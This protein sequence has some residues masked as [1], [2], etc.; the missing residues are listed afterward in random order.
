MYSFYCCLQIIELSIFS[1]YEVL[2]VLKYYCHHKT[3][4]KINSQLLFG[5]EY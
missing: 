3:L 5:A 4:V 2:S 1:G